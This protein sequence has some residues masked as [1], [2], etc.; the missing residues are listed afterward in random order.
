MSTCVKAHKCILT[1]QCAGDVEISLSS[2]HFEGECP[3][4]VAENES[5]LLSSIGSEL[6]ASHH[7]VGL[8]RTNKM[9]AIV[10]SHF[11]VV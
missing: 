3:T 7:I 11:S 8:N 9:F 5:A 10:Q 2:Q 4:L 1:W 6:H